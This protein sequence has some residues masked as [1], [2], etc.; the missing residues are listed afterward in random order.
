MK[1]I[2]QMIEAMMKRAREMLVRDGRLL[3]VLLVM[4]SDGAIEAAPLDEVTPERWPAFTRM[5]IEKHENYARAFQISEAWMRTGDSVEGA[6]E[7]PRV[8]CIVVEGRERGDPSQVYMQ[9]FE[10]DAQGAPVFSKPAQWTDYG[11]SRVLAGL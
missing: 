7:A 11:Y 1:L 6:L 3:H 10:R 5:I 2:E 4:D 9:P 8:E